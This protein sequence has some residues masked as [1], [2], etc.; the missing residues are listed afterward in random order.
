MVGNSSSSIQL[1]VSGYKEGGEKRYKK[2]ERV[3]KQEGEEGKT[4]PV[5]GNSATNL[6]RKGREKSG[7]KKVGAS[8]GG[9]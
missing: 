4:S 5:T 3:V 1:K 2:S 6:Q 8:L 7:I 9:K